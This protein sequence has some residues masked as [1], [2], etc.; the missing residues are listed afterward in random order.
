MTGR[1]DERLI[2]RYLDSRGARPVGHRDPADCSP[3]MPAAA[4]PA[5]PLRRGASRLP[6]WWAPKPHL[7]DAGEDRTRL[8]KSGAD[9]EA[10]AHPAPHEVRSRPTGQL[11]AYW[12]ADCGTQLDVPDDYEDD[13]QDDEEP[14][15]DSDP[16]PPTIRRRWS[17]RGSGRKTYSRPRYVQARPAP[18]QSLIGWWQ[19]MSAPSRWLLYNST[20][21]GAGF[22]LGIPQFFTDE[23]AYLVAANDSWADPGAF[24][25]YGMALAVWMWDYRTRAWIPPFALAAR[26]PLISLAVG[27][28]LYGNPATNGL[29]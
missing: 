17:L 3:D 18:R 11:V 24:V 4:A 22:A 1:P 25:G 7:D 23:T 28:L 15:E 14:A 27:G 21:L 26:I 16:V 20:A 29:S 6:A 2:R 8:T 12:C 9:E 5:A 19:G 13:D 10:C